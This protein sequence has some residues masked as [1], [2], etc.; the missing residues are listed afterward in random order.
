MYLYHFRI[1]E[2]PFSLTPNTHFYF[3][4]P[5]HDEAMQVLNTALQTGEGFIK[6]TGEVGT[7]KT[8]LCRKLLNEVPDAFKVAYI[9]NPALSPEEMRYALASE[10]G[11]RGLNNINQ[12]Q[13]TQ[14]IQL[15]LLDLQSKG[16]GVILIVDEAQTIPWETFEALRLFTNLETESKKLIQVVLFGQPELDEMLK[17][18][19]LRQ[20]RQRI[21]FSYKLRTLT[22][23]EMHAYIN[24]RMTMAGYQGKPVFSK[25]VIKV[26]YKFSKGTPRLANILCHKALMLAYGQGEYEVSKKQIRVAAYDTD[27]IETGSNT[28]AVYLLAIALITGTVIATFVLFSPFTKGLWQ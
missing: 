12:Q 8:L 18:E 26:L 2:L 10:L 22:E 27:A 24:H 11:I 17:S 1:N 7:G 15:K 13:L 19:R 14:K 6:V 3:G 21:T 9:P 16:K 23:Q 28:K 4:L 20:L 5:S 25:S